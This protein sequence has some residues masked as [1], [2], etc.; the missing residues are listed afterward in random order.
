MGLGLAHQ[1][2]SP[3][4]E[5]LNSFVNTSLIFLGSDLSPIIQST[6]SSE[7]STTSATFSRTDCAAFAFYYEALQ[8]TLTVN[9]SF[10][11]Y[12]ESEMDTIGSIHE[13]SFNPLNPSVN[14][15]A[16]ANNEFQRGQLG[17]RIFTQVNRTYILVV[18]TELLVERGNFTIIVFGPA[19]VELKRISK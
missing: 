19:H 13:E 6:Y 17:L 12:S 5:L 1:I 15:I 16:S 4:D 7:L 11:F 18:T 8:F 2:F 9:G 14:L 3:V 10:A